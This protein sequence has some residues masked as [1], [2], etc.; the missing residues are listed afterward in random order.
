[1]AAWNRPV[2]LGTRV[3]KLV[4]ALVGACAACSHSGH[5]L[6]GKCILSAQIGDAIQGRPLLLCVCSVGAIRHDR[7]QCNLGLVCMCMTDLIL[8]KQNM[9]LF[10]MCCGG[11]GGCGLPVR[12]TLQY[13][14]WCVLLVQCLKS[15]GLQRPLVTKVLVCYSC[16]IQ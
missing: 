5:E 9:L 12:L 3:G 1:V 11:G 8:T 14:A 16:K 15:Q 13:F 6:L 4:G 10:G 7:L 2:N